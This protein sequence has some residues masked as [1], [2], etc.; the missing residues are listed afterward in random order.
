[1]LYGRYHIFNEDRTTLPVST[2]SGSCKSTLIKA[3]LDGTD[4]KILKELQKNGR[5]A[6][7]DLAA[8]IG[9][10]APPCL[11]RV[12]RLEKSGIIKGYR[13]IFDRRL[14]GQE[15][16]ALCFVGLHRQTE[17]DLKAFSR[18]VDQ[19]SFVHKAWII[20]GDPD[21]FLYCLAPDLNS[22][23][24]FIIEELTAAANVS[25]VRTVLTICSIK[26]APLLMP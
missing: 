12:R 7:V 17:I 16:T 20:S 23:Q 14:L 24:T 11:R 8:K 13:A 1:M 25:S 5:I 6:N 3:D 18:L 9:I 4:W 22:F 15:L 19:W 21:F 2:K 10:S 26:D